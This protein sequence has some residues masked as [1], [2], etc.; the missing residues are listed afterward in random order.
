M[1]GAIVIKEIK[2][3]R[4]KEDKLRLALLSGMKEAQD[5]MLK[6]FKKTTAT[7]EHEVEFET[8]K[9]IAMAQSPTVHVI[10]TDRI[11][12]YV[13][14]GTDPHPIFAGI[15]T[16]L[17]N[18]KALSFRSGKYRAKTRPRVIGS[19][20]GGASGPKIARPYVQHPGTKARKFDEV[21]QK[22]WT[23]KFKRLMEKAMSRAA[24]ASGHGI[25]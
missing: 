4:L 21:I 14:N 12:G 3:Q 2:P 19:T 5:G 20:P 10:T 23:P 7:W 15:F 9:S 16:G 24:K 1:P 18:K 6:D 8:A 13:N 22:N 11:Y 25:P 17:S